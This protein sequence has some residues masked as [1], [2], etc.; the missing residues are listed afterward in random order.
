[1][2][3]ADLAKYAVSLQP[4]ITDVRNKSALTRAIQSAIDAYITE[5]ANTTNPFPDS[6]ETEIS[7]AN[8]IKKTYSAVI[9]KISSNTSQFFQDV[10]KI[11]DKKAQGFD[12]V[13][14]LL[15]LDDRAGSWDVGIARSAL[16]VRIIAAISR[17]H[18]A[19]FGNKKWGFIE[20]DGGFVGVPTTTGYGSDGEE[21]PVIDK[22]WLDAEKQ[23]DAASAEPASREPFDAEAIQLVKN[24]AINPLIKSNHALRIYESLQVSLMQESRRVRQ[25]VDVATS[26]EDLPQPPAKS[27]AARR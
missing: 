3:R 11:T 14:F 19:S 17:E 26:T 6:G 15:T 1:M 12:P 4:W 9:E 5:Y 23:S 10:P 20:D 8:T 18:V 2:S 24:D 27:V 21:R 22:K 25:R 16:K 7:W 13:S